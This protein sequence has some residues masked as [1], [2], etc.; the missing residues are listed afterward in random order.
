MFKGIREKI[1]KAQMEREEERQRQL[2]AEI[3]RLRAMSAKDL[4][5]EILFELRDVND[6][7]DKIEQKIRDIEYKMP[8]QG[9]DVRF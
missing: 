2:Q 6:R 4:M 1:K 7:I 9:W 3:N 5:I 8:D